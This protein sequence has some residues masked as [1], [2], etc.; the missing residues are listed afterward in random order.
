MLCVLVHATGCSRMASRRTTAF[1]TFT[2]GTSFLMS[3]ERAIWTLSES[4][5]LGPLDRSAGGQ[6][7]EN[8]R[9]TFWNEW[10]ASL[11]LP[12]PRVKWTM[13][14]RLPENLY[15]LLSN[16]LDCRLALLKLAHHL[17][18]FSSRT[19][20]TVVAPEDDVFPW[21]A[22]RDD[23]ELVEAI[24]ETGVTLS[25]RDI[26][27]AEKAWAFL[28]QASPAEWNQ[29][30]R[31]ELPAAFC[32]LNEALVA[33]VERL[34]SLATGLNPAEAALLGPSCDADLNFKAMVSRWSAAF[35]LAGRLDDLDNTL[36]NLHASNLIS[37][38]G[39]PRALTPWRY[40]TWELTAAGRAAVSATSRFIPPPGRWAC[41]SGVTTSAGTWY[42]NSTPGGRGVTRL[43]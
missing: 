13:P 19:I 28:C 10:H 33:A 41:G 8:Q 37:P 14:K 25:Q 24:A 15:V 11:R 7:F 18:H 17:R 29:L 16:H 26:E 34:P 38:I 43:P 5:I 2:A 36:V 9:Q 40:D 39:K 1:L 30:A 23:G 3:P 21:A 4:L 27:W 42:L 31:E 22:L 35:K 6:A 20:V 32:R 12:G